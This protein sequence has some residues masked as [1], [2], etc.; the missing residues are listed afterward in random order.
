MLG[1]VVLLFGMAWNFSARAFGEE[2]IPTWFGM[3]GN[4][5][6]DAFWIAL[7]GSAL[8]I[9]LRRVIDAAMTWWPT[10]HRASPAHFADSLDA[11]YPS[12][13]VIGGGILHALFLTGLVALAA[14]FLGAELRVRWL[15]LLLFIAAA[16][17]MVT[18]W[19]SSSDFVQQ[20]VASAIVLGVVIL[21]IRQIARFNMLGWFLVIVCTG[22]LGGAVELLSQPDRFYHM[23]GYI[24]ATALGLLLL[25][26]LVTWRLK[27]DTTA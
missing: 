2:Q 5:Y 23:Q 3:P 27:P 14:S 16:A 26:P 25:W 17:S 19:G 15:R 22:L 21:G 1:G 11:V 20:F 9:G 13:S 7:G 10:L 12:A 6:R 4:Y 24:V 8:L 18:N